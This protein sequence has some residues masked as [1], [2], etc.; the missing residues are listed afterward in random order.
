MCLILVS[1]RSFVHWPEVGVLSERFQ[2]Q[3]VWL[4]PPDPFFN[5]NFFFFLQ[6]SDASGSGN[7]TVLDALNKVYPSWDEVRPIRPQHANRMCHSPSDTSFSSPE[8]NVRN[9]TTKWCMMAEA[10]ESAKCCIL[11]LEFYLSTVSLCQSSCW[12][13]QQEAEGWMERSVLKDNLFLP[14][15]LTW[16]TLVIYEAWLSAGRFAFL[17]VVA[18]LFNSCPWAVLLFA[19]E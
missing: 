7:R 3:P 8:R 15:L 18:S 10:W 12:G 4:M 19:A 2:T 9:D 6:L 16:Q 14:S 13:Q 17:Q 5:F 1:R 11:L